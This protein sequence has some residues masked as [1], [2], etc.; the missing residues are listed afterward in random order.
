MKFS[1]FFKNYM[2]SGLIWSGIQLAVL[3]GGLGLYGIYKAAKA[4]SLEAQNSDSDES[5]E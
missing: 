4:R 1:E 5:Q 2:L 3:F